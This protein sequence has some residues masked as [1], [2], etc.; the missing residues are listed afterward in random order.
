MN[1]FSLFLGLGLLVLVARAGLW[2]WINEHARAWYSSQAYD[3]Q[4]FHG[5]PWYVVKYDTYWAKRPRRRGR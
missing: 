2:W 4:N 5:K 1:V 3:R